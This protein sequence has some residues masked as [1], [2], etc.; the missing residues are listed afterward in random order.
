MLHNMG[1]YIVG[2]LFMAIGIV[3]VILGLA[4]RR[5]FSSTQLVSAI[6][7]YIGVIITGVLVMVLG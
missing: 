2:S 1:K 6:L 7:I 3:A 4:Y 5:K